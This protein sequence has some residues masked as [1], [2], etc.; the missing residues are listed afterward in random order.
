MRYMVVISVRGRI[1]GAQ[2]TNNLKAAR[3]IAD[4]VV[5]DLNPKSDDC[6]VLDLQISVNDDQRVYQP[7]RG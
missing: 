1:R 3:A 2:G 4:M 5:E 7:L 6:V